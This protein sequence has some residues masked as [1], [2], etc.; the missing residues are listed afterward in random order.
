MTENVDVVVVGAGQAGLSISHELAHAGIDHVVL[1]RGRVGEAWRRRWDSFCLVIPNWTVQLPGGRYSGGD[2]DGFMPKDDIVSHLAG[3]ARS[4]KA[5][6]REAVNVSAL[7]AGDGGG[8]LLRTSAGT[9]RARQVVLASGGY[10]EP[11]RPP[12]AAQ[13]PASLHVIDAE[14]YTN[15]QALPP[16]PVLV[17]GSGQTGCQLAEEAAE[18]GRETSIACGRAPW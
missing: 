15:P 10:Q 6:V 2:P 12:A 9:L 11:H 4:F 1:E 7:D 5:P 3:Y 18:A 16:G 8:F 17:V 14:D 13:L